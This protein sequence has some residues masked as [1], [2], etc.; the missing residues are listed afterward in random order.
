MSRHR[1]LLIV[2]PQSG[3]RRHVDR[4]ALVSAYF[5]R[6]QSEV[7]IFRTQGPGDAERQARL[8]AATGN[9]RAVIGAGGDGTINEVLNGLAGSTM[10]VGILP[11]GTSNVFSREMGFP[12]SLRGQCRVIRHGRICDID[13]GR[14]NGRAFVMMAGIG[15]DA[16]SLHNM[17]DLKATLGPFAYVLAALR[18]FFRYQQP[19]LRFTLAG[20]SEH[21]A[22]FMLISNTSLYGKLFSLTPRANPTDGKLDV[23]V[24]RERGRWRFLKLALSFLLSVLQTD[25]RFRRRL[26][27][28]REAIFRTDHIQVSSNETTYI[29]LDGDYAGVLP[30]DISIQTAAARLILPFRAWRRLDGQERLP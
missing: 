6:H 1:Y 3:S 29:Q 8:A 7:V 21:E 19:R 17:L 27:Y 12:R 26:L 5:E 24:Y 14:C 20:G 15:F 28:L 23:Y 10:P 25:S 18:S 2:N 30:A 9:Y 4:I 16:Y 11:W 22:S 13:L